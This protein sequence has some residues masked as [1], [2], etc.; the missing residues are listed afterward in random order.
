MLASFLITF[1]EGL[2]AFLI[3]GIVLTYL[4]KLDARH[5]PET[6]SCRSAFRGSGV[7][8]QCLH[9]FQ[10]LIDQ[11]EQERYQHLLMAEFSS[12]LR[13]LLTTW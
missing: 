3:V 2:E 1:R 4:T 8:D 5:Y 9:A 13:P 7:R 6:Y 11:F 10:L 12:L